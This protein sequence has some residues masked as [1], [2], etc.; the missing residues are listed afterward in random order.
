MRPPGV[1]HIRPGLEVYGAGGEKIGTVADASER[2]FVV[3]RHVT[4]AVDLFVPM[5]AITDISEDRVELNR[6]TDELENGN[7]TFPIGNG[8][9]RAESDPSAVWEPASRSAIRR[10]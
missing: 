2:Y 10:S 4:P 3:E 8:R 5:S 7:F 6:T 1:A 9:S